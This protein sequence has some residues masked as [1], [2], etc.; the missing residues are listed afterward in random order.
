MG[1]IVC[2]SEKLIFDAENID[3]K[4]A[5]VRFMHKNKASGFLLRLKMVNSV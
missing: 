1:H 2:C 5:I 4:E 3:N